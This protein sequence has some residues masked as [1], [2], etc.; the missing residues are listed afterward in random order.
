MTEPIYDYDPAQ[1]LESPEAIAVFLA[2]AQD[3]GDAT[4]V[5]K[6]MEVVARAKEMAGLATET[7]LAE[8][9]PD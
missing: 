4:Y 7:G 9:S 6:A 2:D 1:A 3:T 8:K 5:A